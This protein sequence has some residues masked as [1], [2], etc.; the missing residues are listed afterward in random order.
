MKNKMYKYINYLITGIL[1]CV[2]FLGCDIIEDLFDKKDGKLSK[3][4]IAQIR[5][6]YEIIDQTARDAVLRDEIDVNE[7]AALIDEYLQLE[8]V[9]DAWLDI[10]G[11]VVKFK[12]YGLASWS[13]KHVFIDPP[14]FDID[15]VTAQANELRSQLSVTSRAGEVKVLPENN[16]VGI[17]CGLDE[18]IA[19]EARVIKVLEALKR[20]LEL[21]GYKVN[22]YYQDVFTME[23]FKSGLKEFGTIIIGT[24]GDLT[25]GK[26][27]EGNWISPIHPR[28]SKPDQ[29]VWFLT[30]EISEIAE[31]YIDDF[32][33]ERL[34]HGN[35]GKILFNEKL[36]E[37]CFEKNTLPNTLFYTFSCHGMHGNLLGKVMEKQRKGK[38]VTIGYDDANNIG[39][40]TAWFLFEALLG[41]YTVQE[42]YDEILPLYCKENFTREKNRDP[43][44]AYLD[45]YPKSGGN[46]SLANDKVAGNIIIQNPVYGGVYSSPNRIVP[47]KGICVGFDKNI[48]GTVSIDELTVPLRFINDSTFSQNIEIKKGDNTIK[49]VCSGKA[50]DRPVTL[51]VNK[52]I[53]LFG[54]FEEMPL[55]TS[56]QWN[57][58]GTDVDLH[59]VGPNGVECYFQNKTPPWGGMLDIDDTNGFGPE[60]I[61]IP[62]LRQTGV[63]KLYVHY[64]DPKGRGA[65]QVWVGVETP[66][67]KKNFGPHTLTAKGEKWQVCEITFLNP[68]TGTINAASL[69]SAE[70]EII[71]DLPVKKE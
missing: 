68:Y 12:N 54:S 7:I 70:I 21:S 16:K 24:H 38:G 62:V 1:G 49:I 22:L 30:G 15:K 4:E 64:Y 55:Y 60:H 14:F 35:S 34:K 3:K 71:E 5:E 69:R 45:Y 66:T 26:D 10:D 40:A 32:Q 13:Y 39:H 17:F 6:D 37:D 67:D 41:G 8:S 25:G 51:V 57:T 19:W 9:E 29:H 27:K 58:D 20:D 33:N 18:G 48:T 31:K 63:Y 2:C 47:L 65:S 59:L 53:Q 43:Y 36:I 28:I 23:A 52:E 44:T 50:K 61:T 42:A 11:I 46:V 56:M